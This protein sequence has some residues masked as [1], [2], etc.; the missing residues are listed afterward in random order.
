L[1]RTLQRLFLFVNLRMQKKFTFFIF[2]FITL[3]NACNSSKIKTEDSKIKTAGEVE[4]FFPVTDF[5]KGQ[6]RILDSMPVT[7]LKTITINGETDSTWL[8]REDI[9]PFAVPFLTPVIDSASLFSYFSVNSFLDQT[10]NSITISYDANAKLPDSIKWRHWDVY[11][12]P[13]TGSVQRIYMVKENEE[14]RINTTTQLTWKTDDGCS[15]RIIKQIPGK[16]P[17]IQEQ[18]LK[19]NFDH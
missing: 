8:K 19:W 6:L 9:R 16:E 17:E 15:I 14:N 10:L 5:L 1:L 13:Q 3:L 2:G 4:T 7:P 12:D 11:I 18:K